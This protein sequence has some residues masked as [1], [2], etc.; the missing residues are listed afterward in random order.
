M[1]V[2]LLSPQEIQPKASAHQQACYG[3]LLG[4]AA[5]DARGQHRLT[6]DPDAADLIL[7]AIQ[8][9]GYGPFFRVLKK[10]PFFRR[11]KAKLLCYCPDDLIYP[12]LPGIYPSISPWW[13]KQGWGCG[14]HYVSAH[15]HQ[16]QFDVLSSDARDI[17][18]SFVGSSK[19]HPLREKLIQSKHPRALFFDPTPKSSEQYWFEKNEQARQAMFT[20]YR[21][22]MRRSKFALCPRGVSASSIRLFEAMESGCVP[23]LIA[24]QL[25]LPPGPNWTSFCVRIPEEEASSVPAVIEQLEEDFEMMSQRAR[26]AWEDF[27]SPPST[28]HQLVESAAAIIRGL[29]SARRKWL[30]MLAG[31]GQYT[32]PNNIRIHFR[33]ALKGS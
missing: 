32:T 7:A 20:R 27:F 12:A 24:D 33:H 30:E 11:Y 6:E 1:K 22:V 31:V 16:H 15:I 26:A 19:T 3:Q 9:N 13:A 25:V 8:S 17:L 18:F 10:S 23:V 5:Q 2:Y 21:D 14:G 4:N 29:L 28:F